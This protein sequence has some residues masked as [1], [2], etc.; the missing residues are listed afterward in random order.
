VIVPHGVAFDILTTLGKWAPWIWSGSATVGLVICERLWRAVHTA[1]RDQA[2]RDLDDDD[3]FLVT[4]LYF[5]RLAITAG[6]LLAAL[7]AVGLGSVFFEG[8]VYVKIGTLSILLVLPSAVTWLVFR[9][10]K[11]RLTH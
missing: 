6:V 3:G 4:L 11:L 8:N 10:F 1:R 5:E 7:I 9:A 2:W